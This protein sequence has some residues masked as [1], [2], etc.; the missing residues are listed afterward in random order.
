MLAP[1]A[2][3]QADLQGVWS[4]QTATPLERPAAFDSL[5]ISDE[6]AAAFERS[7]PDAFRADTSDGVGGRQSEW[8][9][10]SDRMTRIDGQAR[11]SL[12]VDPPDGKMPYNAAGRARL[13]AEMAANLNRFD[14]PETRPST[15][16]CLAGGSG[17]SGAPIFPP[18]YNNHYQ[19]VQTPDF[20]VIYMEPNSEVR[21]IPIGGAAPPA[22][23]RWMGHSRG[24]WEGHTLVVETSGF[25]PG[26]E[27]KPAAPLLMSVEAKVVERFTRVSGEELLYEFSVDD[28]TYFTRPWRV[29]QMLHA[30]TARMF[31]SA[32]HENNYSLANIL[33]G[34]RALERRAAGAAR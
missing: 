4:N 25:T 17:G 26:D 31:E 11:T 28:P 27:F 18:R 34:G 15:E 12:I 5:T 13:Q 20:L 29:Q 22:Y 1:A 3:A 8:W 23:R 16:R 19:L 14:N 21:I 10:L 32:C 7:A 2:S 33:K 6:R 24:R 30:T 9:E